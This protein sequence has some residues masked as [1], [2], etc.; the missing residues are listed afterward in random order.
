[1]AG[2]LIFYSL[3]TVVVDASAGTDFNLITHTIQ[4]LAS[5]GNFQVNV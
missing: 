4:Q 2:R 3:P 1:M 5:L